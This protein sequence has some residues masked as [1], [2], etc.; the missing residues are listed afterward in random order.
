MLRVKFVLYSYTGIS[1]HGMDVL[2]KSYFLSNCKYI[3]VSFSLA[4]DGSYSLAIQP[5]V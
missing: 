1:I 2:K 4:K 5:N 3:D